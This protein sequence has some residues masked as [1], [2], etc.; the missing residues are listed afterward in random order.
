[1]FKN[2]WWVVFASV[3]ALIFGQAS[4]MVFGNGIFIKPLAHDLHF[5]RGV[6]SSAMALANIAC[7]VMNPFTGRML[8][9][10][11]FRSVMLPML[12][13][14]ALATAALSML[15]ASIVLLLVLFVIQG[16]ASTAGTPTPYSKMITSRFDN[17]R[18]LALGIT[19]AGV[20]IG[21]ALVPQ[22]SRILMQHFNWRIGYVG[23]GCGVVVLSVIP[24]AIWYGEP[25][26]VKLAKQTG[27]PTNQNLPGVEFK[28]AVR[29]GKFWLVTIGVALV[30]L[31]INGLI[32]HVVP[33][34][35]D[36]G[37]T[38]AAAVNV[39][40]IVGFTL[41]AGRVISGYLLDKIFAPVL[42]IAILIIAMVGI[43]ILGFGIA[44]AGPFIGAALMGLGI[45]AEHDVL[46]FLISRYF[47]TKAMGAMHG[48]AF[49]FSLIATALG[50]S[51]FGWVYQLRHSYG[52]G[53]V[54]SELLI[55]IAI[56]LLACLGPYRFPEVKP[57]ESRVS[58]VMTAAR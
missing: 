2:R 29:G 35:T 23:L 48:L 37:F 3:L 9:R 32:I 15:Q 19:L 45:G 6:I 42:F 16:V 14:F 49:S 17:K 21:T 4:I 46:A 54:L 10:R 51:L 38:L 57:G 34:L 44:G 53:F 7:V 56:A 20:G 31:A 30:C 5:G 22:F 43:A 26:E 47:G 40:G 28:E 18:G 58:E 27:H 1:M 39:M 41:L 52:L 24:I 50:Q 12:V 13:L 11:S 55:V 25:A 36:R 33:L 8:D